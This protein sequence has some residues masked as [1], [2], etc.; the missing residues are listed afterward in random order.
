MNWY[1]R[2]VRERILLTS[3]ETGQYWLTERHSTWKERIFELKASQFERFSKTLKVSENDQLL[4]VLT[5]SLKGF[6]RSLSNEKKGFK[7]V[8]IQHWA[9]HLSSQFGS[10]SILGFNWVERTLFNSDCWANCKRWSKGSG[11]L[12]LDWLR[13]E[14][15]ETRT[16]SSAQWC[17]GVHSARFG[18]KRVKSYFQ[19]V[20]IGLFG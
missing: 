12:L 13:R 10:N 2:K 19:K 7:F 6:K 4:W 14:T 16:A 3:F 17:S 1:F 11:S 20:I 5:N 8:Q 18:S 9:T 15:G